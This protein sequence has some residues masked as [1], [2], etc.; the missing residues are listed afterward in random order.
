MIT[1][2][3][4]L[5]TLIQGVPD[6]VLHVLVG[7]GI[8]KLVIFLGTSA[9][10]YGTLR[11]AINKIHDFQIKKLSAPEDQTNKVRE[12][13]IKQAEFHDFMCLISEAKKTTGSYIHSQDVA[14]FRDALKEKK[15]KDL[16]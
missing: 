10:I 1:E 4:E 5:L 7:F 12:H 14:Y 3:K 13:F 15:M 2:I 9:G 11:L 16:K 6:M 8:Y